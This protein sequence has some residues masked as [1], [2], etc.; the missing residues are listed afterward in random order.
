MIRT[1]HSPSRV[2][3]ET[4]IRVNSP[5]ASGVSELTLQSLFVSEE[6]PLLHYAFS[7]V[8]RRAVAEEIVQEVFLQLHERWKDVDAPRAWLYRSVRNRAFNYLRDHQREVLGEAGDETPA[9]ATEDD[10]PEAAIVHMEALSALRQFVEELDEDDQE[11]LKLKYFSDLKYRDI[12]Q[13]TGLNIGN[14][15]YRLHHILK[16]LAARLRLLGFGDES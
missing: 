10:P 6:T 5:V 16:G 3:L 8:R 1:C 14:V 7:L 11:L 15:G 4:T 12:S 9:V 13:K 2:I